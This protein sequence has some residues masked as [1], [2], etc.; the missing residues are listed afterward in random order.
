MKKINTNL[1]IIAIFMV[2]GILNADIILL[3]NGK[4][5]SISISR[6]TATEVLGNGKKIK[7]SDVKEILFAATELPAKNSGVILKNG[8]LLTGIIR[9]LDKNELSF[10]ST[11]FGL[12]KLPVGDI[13][14]LFF[15][16]TETV[17]KN[18]KKVKAYPSIVETGGTEMTGKILWCDL[19]SAGI[20]TTSGLKKVPAENLA[21]LCYS[22]FNDKTKVI[23]RNGDK[24]P[25]PQSLNGTSVKFSFGNIPITAIKIYQPEKKK[26]LKIIK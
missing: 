6:I 17:L 5:T 7:L 18:L 12:L 2:A 1:F 22:K 19:K 3:N 24:L 16:G 8:S 23:L 20:L 10:R 25:E 14:A 4:K 11:A 15:V 9:K 26:R 13:A 21:L